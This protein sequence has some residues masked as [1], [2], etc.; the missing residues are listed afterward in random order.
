M[1]QRD[2]AGLL[3]SDHFVA[4]MLAARHALQQPCGRLQRSPQGVLAAG[5]TGRF[6]MSVLAWSRGNRTLGRGCAVEPWIV[7]A[8]LVTA[9]LLFDLAMLWAEGR[10]WV[11]WRRNKASRSAL[12][13]AMLEV[14]S[15]LEPDKEHVVEERARERGD[16]QQ[17][18]DDDPLD[19]DPDQA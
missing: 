11:Y 15:I 18:G 12:G 9:V 17:T 14:Q 16:I 4:G 13:S 2:V 19:G 6:G 10:G 5:C 8:G 7:I 3:R 1:S